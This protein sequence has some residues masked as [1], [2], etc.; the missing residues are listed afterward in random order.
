[1][2]DNQEHPINMIT[3]DELCKQYLID[4]AAPTNAKYNSYFNW[5]T[6]AVTELEWDVLQK[7]RQVDRKSTRLNSSH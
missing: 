4:V 3:L 5:A 7:F 1:M 2:T 6:R